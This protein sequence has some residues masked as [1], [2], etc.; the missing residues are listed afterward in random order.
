MRDAN[1]G[2]PRNT[3]LRARRQVARREGQNEAEGGGKDEVTVK[4]S[5]H[6][7]AERLRVYDIREKRRIVLGAVGATRGELVVCG[8]LP[9]M[10]KK[11]GLTQQP[12][13]FNL[14][15]KQVLPQVVV[16]LSMYSHNRATAVSDPSSV[17][18]CE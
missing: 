12:R 16:E 14:C 2:Q 15:R 6:H 18:W 11:A 9:E 3:S 7:G 13:I 5:S 17:F 4:N 1:T 8:R 10:A